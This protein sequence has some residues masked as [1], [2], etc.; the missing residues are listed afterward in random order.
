MGKIINKRNLLLVLLTAFMAI[1]CF[2]GVALGNYSYTASAAEA[3]EFYI[4]GAQVRYMTT[5]NSGMRFVLNMS[6][7]QYDSLKAEDSDTW[8]KDVTVGMLFV[9][10]ALKDGN[11]TLD[12]TDTN[13]YVYDVKVDQGTW[14]PN[15][16][17]NPTEYTAGVSIVGYNDARYY[18]VDV[19]AVGYIQV[20]EGTPSYTDEVTRSMTQVAYANKD[21]EVEIDGRTYPASELLSKYYEGNVYTVTLNA[22]DGSAA[23]EQT[24]IKGNTVSKPTAPVVA[25]WT[26]EGWYNGADKWDFENGVVTEEMELKAKYT[27]TV[28]VE[29]TFEVYSGIDATKPIA[30]TLEVALNNASEMSTTSATA[31]GATLTEYTWADNM[32]TISGDVFGANIYGD[33]D[34]VIT[35]GNYT[36][37]VTANV[38]TKYMTSLTDLNNMPYYGG[39]DTTTNEKTYDGYFVMKQNIE[40]ANTNITRP[41]SM[42]NTADNMY[43]TGNANYALLDDCGFGGVFDGQGYSILNVAGTPGQY[44]L[45][46]NAQG[47]SVVK[48]LG[49]VG[50][51]SDY[52]TGLNAGMLGN[53]FAG[54]LQN[55][56]F[57]VTVSNSATGSASKWSVALAWSLCKAQVSDVVVKYD[58]SN[59]IKDTCSLAFAVTPDP[60]VSGFEA[61]F[62]NFKNNV[63]LFSQEKGQNVYSYVSDKYYGKVTIKGYDESATVSMTDSEYWYL[64]GDQPIFK[65]AGVANKTVTYTGDVYQDTAFE[66]YSGINGTKPTANKFTVD[67][68]DYNLPKNPMAIKLVTDR[69]TKTVDST[70]WEND[71]LTVTD[72]GAKIYG[73]VTVVFET[74][75]VIYK[76][77]SFKVVTKYLSEFA[78]LNN[79]FYYGGIDT[80]ATNKP[81]DGYFVMSKNITCDSYFTNAGSFDG[82]SDSYDGTNGFAGIFD[83]NGYKISKGQFITYSYGMFAHVQKS[84]VIK[85]VAIEGTVKHTNDDWT[86]GWALGRGVAGTIENV[87]FNFTVDAGSTKANVWLL[88][89]NM[90]HAKMKDVVV[91]VNVLSSSV[92]M[93]ALA[94]YG[95]H[96]NGSAHVNPMT[97]TN[98]H[99]FSNATNA[100]S[101]IGY[102]PNAGTPTLNVYAL[103]AVPTTAITLDETYWTLTDGDGVAV[104]PVW[105]DKVS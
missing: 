4:S 53:N 36:A 33:V 84:A 28:K 16:A 45:F 57:D 94:V 98:V 80:T 29:D 31:N 7:D 52:Y 39:I 30:N 26:F 12:D 46:G 101:Y 60:W 82:V 70:C 96:W 41:S 47:K 54:T 83:G 37:T 62:A 13:K 17:K 90:A 11:L 71:I 68:S 2:V 42:V 104:Q 15:D 66:T 63:Y 38:V 55:C 89:Q 105:I 74:A 79:I 25:G 95:A 59:S 20:G 9:P 5:D 23:T 24:V 97:L 34:V 100:Q 93:G 10:R 27:Q 91:K 75:E 87:H 85:N 8:A 40:C 43:A 3:K 72:L 58:V 69:A 49:M 103:D 76:V 35:D 48:N 50:T 18:T 61:N 51:V 102:Y 56:Y 44:G 14:I 19:T 67:L 64:D 21:N 1:A 99:M 6:A 88:A 81:Y 73:D 22:N 78:D 32:L 86:G 92:Q 65:S 77:S